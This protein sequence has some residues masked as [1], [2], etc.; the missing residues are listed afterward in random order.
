MRH[1]VVISDAEPDDGAVAA[2]EELGVAT[3]SEAM[4]RTGLLDRVI[5]PVYAGARIAGR[6]VT[7]LC[8]AGDNLMIHAAVEQCRPGD[9]LVVATMSPS[10]DGMFG[11]LLAA[12]VQARGV[13]GLVI[14]AGVRDIAE[15]KEM[16]FPVWAR[17]VSAMGTVKATAGSV[18]VPVVIA[19]AV[20]RPG[21]VVVADD[22]GVVIVPLECA[23][24]TA[25]LARER[26]VMEAE[27]RE[28][29]KSGT[30]SLDVLNLRESLQRLGV[31][32][33]Q[34][35]VSTPDAAQL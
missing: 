17:E 6:A 27:K 5:R 32:Y 4:D 31:Q 14:D 9:V 2:L 11:D 28:M 12:A 16:D 8:Q 29:L 33:V 22:D 10:T 7:V 20:V 13:K 25:E 19:G 3:A 35:L 23:K 18:N 24:E 15:L 34:G 21:D 1:V 30:P 26:S